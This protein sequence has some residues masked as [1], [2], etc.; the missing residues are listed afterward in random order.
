MFDKNTVKHKKPLNANRVYLVLVELVMIMIVLL[1]MYPFYIVVSVSVKSARQALMDPSGFPISF[2]LEN[3]AEAFNT[4]KFPTVFMNSLFITGLG[5]LG[6]VLI[7]AFAAYPLAK[8][9]GRAYG[10]IYLLFVC[11]IMIPFHMTL[12]PLMKLIADLG[13]MNSRLGLILVYWGRDISFSIFLY[14]GF[15]RGTPSEIIDAAKLDGAGEFRT[16][17]NI[18][19]PLLKPITTT[20]VILNS[21]DLWNDFLLPL[22][23]ISDANKQTLPLSQYHFHGSFGTQ[24]QLAFSAYILAMLPVIIL[25]LF[26]Q[27]NIVKG[28]ASGALKG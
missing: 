17:W 12:V 23:T 11:G 8:A 22:L 24:W 5:V 19:F 1:F 4:M 7:S 16:F 28:I 26:L 20:V 10:I 3:F 9:R 14:V 18:V 21:L 6:I 27:K 15:I 2:H 25:Y 13:F